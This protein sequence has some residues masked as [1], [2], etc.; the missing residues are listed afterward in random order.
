MLTDH[1]VDAGTTSP[2]DFAIMV[3]APPVLPGGGGYGGVAFWGRIFFPSVFLVLFVGFK[4]KTCQ[5][6][7][8]TR[9]QSRTKS[10]FCCF[11][12]MLK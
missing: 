10:L 1:K 3:K 8:S 12:Y 11:T 6:L 7:R 4:E 9:E 5:V 2:N